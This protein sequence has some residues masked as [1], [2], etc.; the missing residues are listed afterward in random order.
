MQLNNPAGSALIIAETEVYNGTLAASSTWYDLDL[1]AVI[2]ANY[3]KVL[4]HL[5]VAINAST[6]FRRNGSAL[7]D[8]V[9][10]GVLA[11]QYFPCYLVAFTDGAGILEWK[12]GAARAT[13]ITLVAYIK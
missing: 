1:S 3:A 5:T 10:D 2:G 6:F 4:L 9:N 13:V 11:A 12:Q 7:A 8:S